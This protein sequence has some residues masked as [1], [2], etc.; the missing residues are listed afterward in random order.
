MN[1]EKCKKPVISCIHNACVGAGLDMITAVDIRVCT[2]DAWFCAKE[3]DMGLAADV[4]TLQ[5][6]P[7]I[8]GSQSLVND[9][10]FTARRMKSDE[11]EKC[12]LV[13][14]VY[15]DKE[16]MMNAAMQMASNIASKSPVAVQGTKVNLAYSREHSTEDGLDMIAKWNMTMLMSE[17]VMKSAMAAKNKQPVEFSKL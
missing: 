3:V 1:I 4:G 15:E 9:L 10:C 16:E 7:K 2:V 5:R 14:Y 11:A 6:L 8:I 17:D 13:S 12:G